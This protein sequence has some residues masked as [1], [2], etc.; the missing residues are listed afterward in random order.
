MSETWIGC[1]RI[2]DVPAWSFRRVK[3]ESDPFV[4]VDQ[5]RVAGAS[6]TPRRKGVETG[7]TRLRARS[8]CETAI[9]FPRDVNAEKTAWEGLLR[10]LNA[11]TPR[12]ESKQP[13]LAWIEP[14]DGKGLR[15]WLDE[16]QCH[17]G[18][19]PNRPVALLAAW[20]ATPGRVICIEEQHQ[21]TFLSRI[22]TEVL[23][24]VGFSEEIGE[25]LSL[26][27]YEDIGSLNVLSKRHL[28]AQFGEEGDRLYD[29]L[30]PDVERVSFYSPPPA[31]GVSRDFDQEVREP[32]PL[33][34]AL[35]QMTETLTKRLEGKACQRLYLRLTGRHE[36][37]ETSRVLREPI[38]REGPVYRAASTL[39]KR[40]LTADK[41]VQSLRL[42]GRGLRDARGTQGNLFRQRPALQSAITTVQEKHSGALYRIRRNEGAV[43]EEDQ[44]TYEPVGARS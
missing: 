2:S 5:G 37:H 1:V 19:A 8:L 6:R 11:H 24:E 40:S 43:F 22:P 27:G 25:R 38:G 3:D 14:L 29:F 20:K 30:H 41:N 39:L 26:F 32:G 31:V 21:N 9:T 18:V 12:I 44:Y 16:R 10:S 33:R 28:T 17:C 23:G 13:G 35:K 15:E 36:S 34:D 4:V 7:M 42:E